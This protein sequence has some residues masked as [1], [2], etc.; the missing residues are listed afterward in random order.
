MLIG[1]GVDVYVAVTDG[2]PTAV[3]V[4]EAAWVAATVGETGVLPGIAVEVCTATGVLVADVLV[5]RVA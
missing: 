4:L 5:D 2:R 3:G 1:V